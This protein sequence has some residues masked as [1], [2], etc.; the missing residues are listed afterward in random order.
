MNEK[1]SYIECSNIRS[2]STLLCKT[3]EQLEEYG[4]PE[5]YFHPNTVGKLNLDN[6]PHAFLKYCESIVQE[7]STPNGVFGIKLHWYQLQN[8]LKMARES[9][10]FKKK[11]DLEILNTLFPQPKFIYLWR[12]DVVAQS[13]SAV[14]VFQSGQWEKLKLDKSEKLTHHEN[15]SENSRKKTIKFKP[16]SIYEFEK[17]LQTQNQAW[18]NFFQDNQLPHYEVIYEDLVDIFNQE[19]NNILDFLAI[20]GTKK[21]CHV[22]MTTNRQFN[23]VNQKFIDY[24]Q[25]LPKPLLMVIYHLKQYFRGLRRVIQNARSQVAV[26]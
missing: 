5:E 1:K 8:L 18:K 7:N 3:L 16:I 6:D 2:G 11:Q 25:M 23:Q 21:K 14:I 13:V 19:I 26:K 24:Y 22:E 20:D 15:V 17:F 9:Q 10:H 12:R 4:H